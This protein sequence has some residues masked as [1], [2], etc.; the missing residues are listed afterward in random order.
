MTN[1]KEGLPNFENKLI[2]LLLL[3]FWLFIYESVFHFW[4]LSVFLF[5][6]HPMVE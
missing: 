4:I 6:Y 5:F 1:S 3:D 2:S